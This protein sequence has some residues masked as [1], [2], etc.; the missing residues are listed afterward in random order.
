MAIKQR[1]YAITVGVGGQLL[2]QAANEDVQ[3][4]LTFTD[5]PSPLGTG[6]LVDL[7]DMQSLTMTAVDSSGNQL[8]QVIGTV[9]GAPSGAT[10]GFTVA[11]GT[12]TG[13]SAQN[14]KVDVKLI[15][16]ANNQNQLLAQSVF[17]VVPSVTP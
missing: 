3:H 11:H 10:A 2:Q 8:F 7:T 16:T 17:A 5:A 15:D 9:I 12:L 1:F 4:I 13:K 14:Y 6:A